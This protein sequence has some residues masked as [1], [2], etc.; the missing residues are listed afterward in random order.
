MKHDNRTIELDLDAIARVCRIYHVGKLS[1]FGSAARGDAHMI[2]AA[3][4]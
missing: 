3:L 1:L 2:K 4:P